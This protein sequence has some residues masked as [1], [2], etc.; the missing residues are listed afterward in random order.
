MTKLSEELAIEDGLYDTE[1]EDD[2]YGIILGPNG[3]LKSVFL[4]DNMPF[5]VPEKLAKIFAILLERKGASRGPTIRTS[6][7]M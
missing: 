6:K 2:D 5:E 4:P 3:E 1:I 7:P